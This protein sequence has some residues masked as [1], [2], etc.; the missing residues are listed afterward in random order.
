[1]EPIPDDPLNVGSVPLTPP[2]SDPTTPTVMVWWPL[3]S[4]L[5]HACLPHLKF[6]LKGNTISSPCTVSPTGLAD[7]N[8]ITTPRWSCS[9]SPH[10]TLG[11]P[12]KTHPSAC[13]CPHL[14]LLRLCFARWKML[15][16]TQTSH[17]FL[18]LFYFA[19]QRFGPLLFKL[20]K[21]GLQITANW[22]NRNHLSEV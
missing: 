6:L 4:A 8:A 22:L 9:L 11:W 7:C 16:G 1:M 13:E 17:Y 2:L 10:A 20:L 5:Q 18:L 19:F 12:G 3:A 15:R 14:W 21:I